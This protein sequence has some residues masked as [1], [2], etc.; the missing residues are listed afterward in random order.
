MAEVGDNTIVDSRY[1]ILNRI[2]SGGMADVYR[3]QDTHLG[4]EVAIKV[5]HRRFSAD[6]DFVE[7]FRREASSA[8]S[9]Q[10]PNVVNVFDRGE[11]DGTYY[12]A[13]EHLSGSTLKQL[14][15]AEAP[16]DQERAID[17]G[18]QI[19]RAAGFAHRRGVIHR[20]LK[21]HNVIVGGEGTAKVTDFGIARAGASE[22]TETGSIMGTAQYL[23]PEQAQGHAVSA[24]SDLYSIG[25]LLYEVLTGKVPFHGGSAVSIALKHMNEAPPPLSRLRADIHPQ[26]ESVVM[27]ALAK[28]PA[29]RYA[30]AEEMI[31]ALEGARTA[32]AGS[33]NGARTAVLAPVTPPP[34]RRIEE[35]VVPPPPPFEEERRRR[36]WPWIALLALALVGIGLALFA[37]LRQRDEPVRV[38]AVEG[39]RLERAQAS[40][41]RAGF[42]VAAED[43]RSRA[44][45]GE[46]VTQDPE[47][48]ALAE[49]GSTVTL[50]VSTGPGQRAVPDV[51]GLTRRRAAAALRA[52]GF[53]VREDRATS[54][55]VPDGRVIRSDPRQGERATVG[56]SVRIVVSSGPE[57]VRVPDVTGLSR[58]SAESALRRDGFTVEVSTEES[59]QPKGDVFRQSPGSGETVDRAS[60]VQIVVSSGIPMVEV[61]DVIGLSGDAAAAEISGLGLEVD[62]REKATDSEDEDGMVLIQRPPPGSERE[63]GRTVV[64]LVGRFEEPPPEDSL[65]Q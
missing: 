48:R 30:S 5:L 60:R 3:A 11:H 51:N 4:R 35:A 44:P 14:I 19:L 29:R 22:M 7:R 40:L 52:D 1:R 58:E 56:S 59:E 46:V 55:S 42:E 49:R 16:L 62:V 27:R 2:G 45:V 28:D 37:V 36:R 15:T 64:V 9:L 61:P 34:V 25:V 31:A 54:G 53:R 43:V 24:P 65:G 63:R 8:A 6:E 38:P 12:I 47:P 13:M 21:P 18:I 32:I 17:L 57:Q 50:S 39:Q 23:S 10:H 41:E 33:D 20:D 26:L